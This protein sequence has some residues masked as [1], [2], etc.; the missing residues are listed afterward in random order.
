M[1]NFSIENP[2]SV[3]LGLNGSGLNA[4]EIYIGTAGMDPET[5]PITVYWDAAGTIPA[6]QPLETIGGYII[7]MGTPARVYGP[8]EYSIRAYD[9]FG[10]L[11]FYDE[12]ANS[13]IG[14]LVAD[15]ASTAT[16]KGAS[17]IGKDSG[18]T[19]QDVID[20]IETMN[21]GTLPSG[22]YN[23]WEVTKTATQGNASGTS[24]LYSFVNRVYAQ[25]ANNY[26]FVRS[27][28]QGTHIQTTAGTTFQA[29]GLHQYVWVS[30]AGDVTYAQAVS[31]H[32][33][34]DGP[35][36][37]LS[38]TSVFRAVSTTLGAT[39]GLGRIIGFSAG[40]L[41]DELNLGRVDEVYAFDAED[42]HAGIVIGYR[43]EISAGTNKY[44][45]YGAGSAPSAFL[46]NVGI[47][48]TSTPAWR[49]TVKETDDNWSA[50]VEN[51]HASDPYGMRI[52]YTGASPNDAGHDFLICS[53]TTTDRFA[54]KANGNI[55]I[56]SDRVIA[57]R[58]AAVTA[59]SGGATVDSQAR[60]AINDL[61]AR[62][63]AHGLIA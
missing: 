23:P 61:I 1:T 3:T 53:D 54:V 38:E 42:T 6:A 19:V 40:G 49:L 47:G 11:V 51:T 5:N 58:Q 41:G 34:V 59:P 33:R 60:T 14:Q 13:P 24:Q 12:N 39:G 8:A 10:A 30:G 29:D 62:L 57:G 46:G 56:N 36:K 18:G 15:L 52:R 21:L 32:I 63:Q 37:I 22:S 4:G 48:I 43:S 27:Q 55:Y 16:G 20:K 17:L 44:A 31:G 9:R 2:Y 50:D 45:F 26:D 35:G 28:Y 25:G 7:R